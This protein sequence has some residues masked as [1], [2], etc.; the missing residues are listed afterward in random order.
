MTAEAASRRE[1]AQLIE[2]MAALE[3]PS[4]RGNGFATEMLALLRAQPALPWLL[5]FF[6]G[7][8]IRKVVR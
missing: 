8:V 5:A 6:A 4:G 2:Q 3:R 7:L 1:L